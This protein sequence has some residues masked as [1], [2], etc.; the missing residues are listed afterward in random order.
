MRGVINSVTNL[1]RVILSLHQNKL[2]STSC[3]AP[4][5]HIAL[6]IKRDIYIILAWN[7]NGDIFMASFG[8]NSNQTRVFVPTVKKSSHIHGVHICVR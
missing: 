7:E 8:H 5:K 1:Q 2:I 6:A 4:N 3:V